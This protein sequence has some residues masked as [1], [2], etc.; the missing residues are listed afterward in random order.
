MAQTLSS[1]LFTDKPNLVVGVPAQFDW[2]HSHMSVPTIN[3]ELLR[4]HL[5]GEQT[6]MVVSTLG[7]ISI[8]D[9]AL[10]AREF[11]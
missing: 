5:K 6:G 8:A 7:R 10:V 3:A 4:F 1:A 9:V 2:R 11:V